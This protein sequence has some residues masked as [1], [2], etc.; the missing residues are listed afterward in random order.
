MSM[1]TFPV[2]DL[3]AP[4]EWISPAQAAVWQQFI[5]QAFDFG[6]LDRDQVEELLRAY[7]LR[8]AEGTEWTVRFDTGQWFRRDAGGQ[9]AAAEPPE[10]LHPP[11]I[12]LSRILREEGTGDEAA[13]TAPLAQPA[14][15]LQGLPVHAE[16]GGSAVAHAGTPPAFCPNCG[17]PSTTTVGGAVAAGKHFCS[18][19]GTRLV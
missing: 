9:W 12:Q 18:K 4:R 7:L 15:A 11:A 8:D 5:V 19:C 17:A 14:P 1:A 2:P 16:T 13:R 10:R 6:L 3:N